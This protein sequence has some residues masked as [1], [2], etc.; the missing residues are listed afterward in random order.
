MRAA[1]LGARIE[2]HRLPAWFALEIVGILPIRRD[3]GARAEDPLAPVDAALTAERI[4]I[5]FA[6]GT[7]SEPDQ[8]SRV[9]TRAQGGRPAHRA[10]ARGPRRSDVPARACQGPAEGRGPAGAV[11][12][13]RVRGRA[14]AL[15]RGLGRLPAG[16][17]GGPAGACR[18]GRVCTLGGARWPRQAVLDSPGGAP[19]IPESPC[20]ALGYRRAE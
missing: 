5:L 9:H 8:R 12:L 11:L 15:G 13:R 18:R 16:D 6:E 17:R 4:L 2:K 19:R 7:R 1:G 10:P 3:G 20:L 14:R